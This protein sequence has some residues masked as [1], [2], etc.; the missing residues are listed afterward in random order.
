M[1]GTEEHYLYQ[2]FLVKQL[3]ERELLLVQDALQRAS[4]RVAWHTPEHV[5]LP[6]CDKHNAMLHLSFQIMQL[7]CSNEPFRSRAFRSLYGAPYL[8]LI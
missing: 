1:S 4:L 2:I 3:L 7:S 5:D 6:Y 8:M